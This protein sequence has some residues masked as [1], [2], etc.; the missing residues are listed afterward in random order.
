MRYIALATDYDGTLARDGRVS[1]SC[2]TALEQLR[3]SGRYLI[4]VTGRELVE[5]RQVFPEIGL[6]HAVVAE[7]GA[8][9]YRPDTK[10]ESLLAEP[11]PQPF[12]ELLKN[13]GVRP[14]SVGRAIVATWTPHEASVVEVIR[15]LGLELQVIFNKGA[16]MVLPSGV[17]KATGLAV[18]L[19]ELSL[20][21]HNVVAVGDAENDHAFLSVCECAVA[22]SNALPLL[23]QRAD[24]VTSRDHGEG[25][26]ELIDRLL[27]DDLASLE[28]RLQRHQIEIGMREGQEVLVP[29]YGANLLVTGPSGS[30]KSSF[31]T[32]VLERF[33]ERKYQFCLID[34]S[35]RHAHLEHAM[36]LGDAHHRP[37]EQAVLDALKRP[38]RNLVLNLLGIPTDERC[39]AFDDLLT[40]L[41]RQRARTGRPHWIVLDEAHQLAPCQRQRPDIP[42]PHSW[43]GTV[44]VTVHP[45]RLLEAALD[46]IDLTVIFGADAEATM[47]KLAPLLGRVAPTIAPKTNEAQRA[48]AW[49]R[50]REQGFWFVPAMSKIERQR[51]ARKFLEGDLGPERSFLFAGPRRKLHLRAAN[52]SSFLELAEGVDDE[53]WLFHL[54]QGDYAAWFREVLGNEPLAAETDRL[55]ATGNGAAAS[56][57]AQLRAAI[58]KQYVLAE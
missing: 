41:H 32:G 22:V 5:L 13:R 57:R 4:L 9:I 12:L 18:A 37:T 6:F 1:Q 50:N 38:A 10:K 3:A 46:E 58:E 44:T 16:V 42:L 20:S 14:I 29:P 7:N 52:L 33:T 21:P 24:W 36:L 56:L 40:L 43:G 35:G 28:E 54:R 19:K 15:D 48:L 26:V 11:P 45:D 31:V 8:V 39:R 27:T 2:V 17:N 47:E 49:W 34:P 30:G 55:A 51:Q 23:K 25:V 53:T